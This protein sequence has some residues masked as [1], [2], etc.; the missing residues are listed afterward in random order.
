MLRFSGLVGNTSDSHCYFFEVQGTTVFT[1]MAHCFL[2]ELS[3]VLPPRPHIILQ[4]VL[5]LGVGF[6]YEDPL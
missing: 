3:N 2:R 5:V 6:P 1:H 4:V